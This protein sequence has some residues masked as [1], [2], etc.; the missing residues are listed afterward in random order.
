[1]SI[2]AGHTG[3]SW[4]LQFRARIDGALTELHSTDDTGWRLF[5]RSSALFLEGSTNAMSFALDME[6]T[7]SV[8]DGTWHSLAITATSAGSKI[9]LDGYQC[10]S[11]TAD[12]SPAASGPEATLELTPGA[13]IDIR[14]FTEHDA[15]LSPA[16][17]LALSPAPTPLIEFAAARLSDYDVAELS[18]LTAG[19]IFAR[20]RVRGPGQHG[21]IL[22]AGG[23]GTE[24]LNLSVTEEGIEYKVLGRRGEWR[25]FTAHGHWD[26]GRW[27][28]V[29]VRVGHGAVQIY[30]DG[31]LE[32]HLP[33][34]AFFA[35]VDSLDEVVIGQDTSGS[36]LF[37]EVRNAALY[38]SILNDSQIKK[39]SSV[40]PVD[41]Q[42][43]FDAGFHDSISYRIPS[44][45]TLESGVVVAGADQRE[46]IANDSPNSINF[47]VRRSFDGGHTWGDLQTVLTYPGHGAKGASVID[48]CVVQDRRNGR[49]VILIDHFPG[50][51]GQPNTEAGLGV[52]EKGRYILH[53]ANGAT[54]TWNE[55]GSI[56]DA[57][58]NATPFTIS[59]RGK[60]TVTEDGQESPGGNVFLADGVDPHQTLL[61]A[62]TC[63]LQMIYSDDDGETWSGPFNLNQDVKEEWMSFCGTSPGTGVQ[64]R[65]GRLVIPIYYNGDHKRH[66]S[67]SVVYS[68][69]GGATWKRGKSPND[70]RIFEGREIDSRTLDTE[71]AATHEATLIERA[72]GSL[73]MLMRNQHPSGKVAA[74]VS[75]DGGETWGDVFF[76]EEITEIFCQPN[77]VPWPTDDCPER[78][79]FAN[80]SQMRPYRGRGVLRLSEDGGRTWIAS[81]TFN[82]AHYVYQCMTILPDGAL[83]LLWE[84]E[85]QGLYFSRIPLEWIEAAKI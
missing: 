49:L 73:L 38:T 6:D 18:E 24:Q 30:V 26:Q 52:D 64:L 63:F 71:A 83:G 76:A 23:G 33:G 67:A 53:D 59:E 62:R 9:F 84:R 79:V 70:G 54:Y 81:R 35:S 5:I 78:V 61:T 29:V 58:G 15:V 60:V 69:D 27:H 13:G 1:M 10:F 41:T 36:R 12:L 42:C 25:T 31:Y 85:M 66:F 11:T 77:A 51:I 16:E 14:S 28:D 32:A 2:D 20:Y 3:I 22:A 8:T 68:D 80:A 39:L 44:L 34:Q 48:S 47:T 74:T 43:L 75:T 65:S 56:T 57:D 82:P 37:G 55:D 4:T 21:T 17:I 72:D 19:T 7:A 40:A 46:T 45:I 50:G